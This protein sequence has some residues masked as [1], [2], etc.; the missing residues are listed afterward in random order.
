MCLMSGSVK[1]TWTATLRNEPPPRQRRRSDGG[2]KSGPF[3][4]NETASG[5][6]LFDHCAPLLLAR[7][8]VTRLSVRAWTRG[9]SECSQIR[10]TLHPRARSSLVTRRSRLRFP[11]IFRFQNP[12]LLRG[13]TKCAGQPCQ[14]HPSTNTTTLTRRNVKSGRPGRDRCRRQPVIW[15]ARNNRAKATSVERFPCPRILAM[16]AERSAMVITS[17]I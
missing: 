10:R 13:G 12:A 14:K 4:N 3:L 11:A 17:G 5:G 16:S 2:V 15:F 6:R 8:D 9:R 1:L 7:N